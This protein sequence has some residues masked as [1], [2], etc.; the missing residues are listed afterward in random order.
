MAEL[1]SSVN[2]HLTVCSLLLLAACGGAPSVAPPPVPVTA[3]AE[4][5]ISADE[6]RRDL[7][8]FAADSMRG[9]ETGTEDADRAARFLVARVQRLGLADTKF[10]IVTL[11]RPSNVDSR[12]SL[13]GLVT[14]LTHVSEMLPLVFAVHPRTRKKLQEF[15]LEDQIGSSGKI[16]LIPPM[17]YVQFMN[18]VSHSA[19]VITDSG[20][21]QEETT[22]LG[23]PCFTLR[24]NTERPITV[25]QGSNQLVKPEDLE[26]RVG[27]GLAIRGR[28]GQRPELWDGKSAE[29]AVQ[30]LKERA[31]GGR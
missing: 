16:K 12:E 9:R 14:V 30:R 21:V 22:Y 28:S 29:R 26:S 24:E 25:T 27:A 15:G 5:D 31:L 8:A 2:R 19:A 11:H 20:G 4:G 23:I 17:G 7:T 10:G 13:T 1:R 6:L 3:A 18:L